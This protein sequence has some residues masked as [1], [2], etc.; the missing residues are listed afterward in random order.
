[1][2]SATQKAKEMYQGAFVYFSYDAHFRSKAFCMN[3]C[4]KILSYKNKDE[5]FYNFYHEVK[6]QV[7]ILNN[8]KCKKN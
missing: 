7:L 5:S 8:Q 1:M 6:K 3:V 2:K 4:N